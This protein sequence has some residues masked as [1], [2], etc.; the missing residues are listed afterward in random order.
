MYSQSKIWFISTIKIRLFVCPLRAL[1]QGNVV[2]S[3]RVSDNVFSLE[4]VVVWRS[5]VTHHSNFIGFEITKNLRF[6]EFRSWIIYRTL[7]ISEQQKKY[8]YC[9]I[10]LKYVYNFKHWFLKF[11]CIYVVDMT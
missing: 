8:D 3:S 5:D 10:I 2:D 9:K 1:A 11:W 7:F 4:I 6:F